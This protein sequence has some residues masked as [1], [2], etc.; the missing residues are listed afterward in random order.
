MPVEVK[1]CIL[2][3]L[4]VDLPHQLFRSFY[5]FTFLHGHIIAPS[6]SEASIFLLRNHW[7]PWLFSPKMAIVGLCSLRSYDPRTTHDDNTK[8]KGMVAHC[9]LGT[10]PVTANRP[11]PQQSLTV[12]LE[13][14]RMKIPCF[15]SIIDLL[16]SGRHCQ[17]FQV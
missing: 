14:D 1:L 11:F 3:I 4:N 13:R 10:T 5:A 9:R 2:Q 15:L 7:F 12:S 16:A 6:C 17:V 8:S